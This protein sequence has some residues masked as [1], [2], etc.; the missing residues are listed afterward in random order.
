MGVSAIMAA[1]EG[2]LP[3]KSDAELTDKVKPS[4]N[5]VRF[6]SIS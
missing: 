3:L 1:A 6:A 2:K 4:E 5:V